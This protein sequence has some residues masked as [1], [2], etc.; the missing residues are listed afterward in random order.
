MDLALNN[1]QW[2]ICHKT[3]PI[4][5]DENSPIPYKNGGK[6][7]FEN[8]SPGQISMYT[9]FGNSTNISTGQKLTNSIFLK[10]QIN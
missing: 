5:L 8:I 2:L 1:L 10:Q 9:K 4:L 3:K 7:N 6:K